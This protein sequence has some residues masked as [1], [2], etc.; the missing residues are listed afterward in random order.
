MKNIKEF[1]GLIDRYESIILEEISKEWGA[2]G[3]AFWVARKLTGFGSQEKCTLCCAAQGDCSKC[4][5]GWT[6]ACTTHMSYRYIDMAISPE[7]LLIAFRERAKYMRW[8]A[9]EL[10]IK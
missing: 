2:H 9:K 3:L 1:K 7:K 8:L 10:G 6:L 4:V 5:Y